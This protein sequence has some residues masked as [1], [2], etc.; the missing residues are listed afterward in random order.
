MSGLDGQHQDGFSAGAIGAGLLLLAATLLT[1]CHESSTSQAASEEPSRLPPK[2]KVI[3]LRLENWPR[4]VRVQGNLLADETSIVG[5][6]VAN[7]VKT[8]EID[9]GSV[10]HQD[11]ILVALDTEDLDF[12][13]QQAEAQLAQ[14]RSKLGLKSDEPEASLD[15]EKVPAVVQAKAVWNQAK[16]EFDRAQELAKVDAIAMEELQQRQAAVVVAEA[17]YRTALNDVDEQ[18]AAAAAKRAEL[19]LARQFCIYAEI[20]APFDGV[21]QARHVAPGC[22]L[23]VGQAVVTLVRTNPLRFRGG[24]REQDAPR[25]RVGQDAQITIE[26]HTETFSGKVTRVSPTLDMSSRALQVEIDLP[27]P[28]LRLQVGLFA[29]AD[30]VI[31]PTAQTLAVPAT[32]VYEFAGVE[33]VR[34]VRDGK[35]VEKAVQA[36]RRSPQRIEIIEGLAAGDLVLVDAHKATLGPVTPEVQ[37]R[38]EYTEGLDAKDEGQ[39]LKVKVSRPKDHDAE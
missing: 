8:V 16:S 18:V 6:K 28:D 12:R 32:A 7:R 29:E 9:L 13:V 38:K 27:N 23:Q 26:G 20:R 1:G 31:D 4:M 30:I 39:R 37:E 24:I 19:G 25:V 36:G 21:V 33:K 34:V 22:Y 17:K 2:V 11:D 15:R 5:A 10:V 35:A 3:A 14:I